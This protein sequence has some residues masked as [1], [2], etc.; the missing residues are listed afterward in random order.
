MSRAEAMAEEMGPQIFSVLDYGADASGQELATAAFQ[1]A[2]DAAAEVEGQVVVPAGQYLLGSIFLHSHMS[3]YLTAGSVLLGSE[4]LADYPLRPTRIAGFEMDWPAALVNIIGCE[5]VSISGQGM[6]DGRG[7]CWW[8]EYWGKDGHGGRRADYDARDLRWVAD[9]EIQ[10]PRLLLVQDSREVELRD[11]TARRAGFWTVQ[12][13]YCQQV[14]V[15]GLNIRDNAGPSTDGIDVDSCEDITIEHCDVACNDD[16]IVI[17]SGRDADG[18]RVGR[19]CRRVLVRD[20]CIRSGAGI[21]LGSEASGGIEGI[22]ITECQVHDTD[23]GFR[24]KSSRLRGGYIRAVQVSNLK[25]HNVR[26]PFSW[27]LDWH[28]AY[29]RFILPA[30]EDIPAYWRRLAAP[31]PPEQQYTS[32]D[33]V[34]VQQVR[35]TYDADYPLS[36]RAFDLQGAETKPMQHIVFRDVQL[37]TQEFGTITGVADI[38][39]DHVQAAAIHSNHSENDT[40]DQR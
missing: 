16:D 14:L 6:L 26:F 36:A 23:C 25:M 21:T 40:Y 35:A 30:Q 37:A 29:N 13:T 22:T 18:L 9:Y 2:I 3:L 15:H 11:F 27:L 1:A 28:P 12:L 34:Q 10:R 38:H 17:K 33:D 32:V 19:P 39:F 31:V 24:M 20:C 5:Q 4:N 8:E 7:E